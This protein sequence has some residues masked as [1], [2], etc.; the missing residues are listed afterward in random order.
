MNEIF[1]V[2]LYFFVNFL[3][4]ALCLFAV[5]KIQGT[6]TPLLRIVSS[7]LL[8]GVFAVLLEWLSLPQ[9]WTVCAVLFTTVPLCALA[10][11]PRSTRLLLRTTLFYFLTQFFFGGLLSGCYALF[12]VAASDRKITWALLFVFPVFLFVC[13]LFF[14]VSRRR[15]QAKTQHVCLI[16]NGFHCHASALLD[17]G[18]LLRHPKYGISVALIGTEAAD[19]FFRDRALCSLRRQ[20]CKSEDAVKISTPTGEKFLYGFVAEQSYIL[21]HGKKRKLEPFFLAFDPDSPNFSGCDLII[22]P[23]ILPLFRRS[24]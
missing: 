1:Y 9:I 21:V 10:F 14:G 24:E 11:P 18:N 16:F 2:D 15:F 17:S 22:A 5:E 19:F 8:F 20:N 3:F 6:Y 23:A 13:I 4:A 12:G 7:A